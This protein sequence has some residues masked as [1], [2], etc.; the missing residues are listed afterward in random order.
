VKKVLLNA[1]RIDGGT[2]C[3]V[4]I[5]Q[6]TVYS[7]M[8]HMKEGDEFPPL[9]TV[10]DGS[11]HWLTDGFHR[12]HAYKLQG[13]KE[14][15]VKY[16]PGTK[17][18]AVLA[19]LRANSKHGKTLTNEDKRNKVVMALSLPGYAEKSN[20]EIAKICEV[21]QPF[22]SSVRDPEVKRLQ[23]ER[24]QKSA[25]KKTGNTASD[26]NP[27][28]TGK[29]QADDHPS[30]VDPRAGSVPDDNEIRAAELAQQADMEA[31]YRLLESDE[32]LKAA[33][34]E[35]KRLNQLM[36]QLEMRIKGLMAE[37]NEAVKEVKKLQKELDRL[38]GKK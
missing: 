2:Q 1:I 16:R 14:V 22:V 8:E 17:E 12:W 24:R 5:D 37:K 36:A 3:R 30:G 9:E 21:S 35:I 15:E 7:Y 33:H 27:I 20:Y 23:D 6:P 38:K 13:V 11:T 19:A 29:P 10:F 34:A 26:T 32:P 4:T 28:S 31:M 18:D 25:V